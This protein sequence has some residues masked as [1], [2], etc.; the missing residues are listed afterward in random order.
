MLCATYIHIGSI[1]TRTERAI[2]RRGLCRWEEFE[3]NAPRID[4]F[5]RRRILEALPRSLEARRR[6]DLAYFARRLPVAEHWRILADFERIATFLDIETSDARPGPDALTVVGLFDG[7]CCSQF[8]AG[9]DMEAL[10][11][12]MERSRILVTYNG[13]RFDLPL[14][15]A[16]GLP[17]APGVVHVDLMHL[18]HRL[19]IKGG[20]KG[21]ERRLGIRRPPEVA[22]MDG[23]QAVLLWRRHLNGDRRALPRL[24]LYNRCDTVNLMT[25][26]RLL[27]PR[28]VRDAFG[29]P[30]DGV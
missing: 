17:F 8:V 12:V 27:L 16:C 4:S 21:A 19:G 11:H 7:R 6:G 14:L 9:R 2:H 18:C 5:R 15:R 26:W 10:P 23:Y 28:L 25:L 30:C 29:V 22:G 13:A 1:G 3:R 20:L 24:L